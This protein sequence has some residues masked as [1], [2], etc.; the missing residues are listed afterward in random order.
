MK[1][2]KEAERFVTKMATWASLFCRLPSFFL[3]SRQ[4]SLCRVFRERSALTS[5][6]H[7]PNDPNPRSAGALQGW[8]G[9]RKEEWTL[10]ESH[11]GLIGIPLARL[12]RRPCFDMQVVARFPQTDAPGE[13]RQ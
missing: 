5:F 4:F 10:Q 1:T 7:C 3:M 13:R 12:V 6:R 11:C 8:L 2:N 9:I